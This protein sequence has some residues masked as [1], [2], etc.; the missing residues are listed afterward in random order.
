MIHEHKAALRWP[1][2][3]YDGEVHA[4]LALRSERIGITSTP[5]RTLQLRVASGGGPG[6]FHVSPD[7]LVK[8]NNK[9]PTD[10]GLR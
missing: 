9:N 6:R 10:T 3:S 1:K 2:S 8:D 4:S 5:V 7:R